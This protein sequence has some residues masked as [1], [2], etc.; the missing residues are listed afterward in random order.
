M[1][2][3]SRLARVPPG[4]GEGE[5]N[6]AQVTAVPATNVPTTGIPATAI[7]VTS[8]SVSAA[9]GGFAR[10]NPRRPY[11]PLAQVRRRAHEAL[12]ELLGPQLYDLAGS[13]DD[14]VRPIL[15]AL[16]EVLAKEEALTASDRAKAYQQ[17][18]D[19]ILGHGPI[20]PLLRDPDVT[21]IMVNS[22]DR[23]YV[24]RFGQIHNVDAAFTD[25]SHL[26]RVI[27]R[28]V[29][30]VGRRVDEASPMV[31]ARLPDGSRVNAVIPP[32]AIDG[33]ALTVRKFSAE[34]YTAED[35]I[36]FGTL[37]PQVASF[38]AACILGRLDIVISGGTGSGKTTLLNVLSGYLPSNE[39]IITIEDSAELRLSQEHVLR[40]EYRPPNIEGAG[41]VT[42]RDLVRNALRMRPD[43]IVVGEVRD[44]AALDMLQAMNT[45]HDGS[46]TTV[47]ANSP[48]DSISRLETMVMMAGME[49]PIRAI[50][51]QISSAV[52]LI[53][54]LARLRDGSRRI[55]QITEVIGM[56]GGTLSTQ[57]LYGFDYGA[58]R[59][60]YG[61]FSG[62][63]RSTGVRPRFLDKLTEQGIPIQLDRFGIGA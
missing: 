29:S 43:R 17:I 27:D 46:L 59:D 12:L 31:D 3:A 37:T 48:R 34:P 15:E 35:L 8:F 60:G 10:R 51:E 18:V 30:R 49:L 1:S 58:G 24:E 2:L 16:P 39:R 25:E 4:D 40:M 53:V 54:Q 23:I 11:D 14:L 56:E 47:H 32:I 19:E 50:R 33:A 28:I 26:R 6:P 57:E 38:L 36:S 63:V 42:I 20:E 22:W 45:G 13:D 61:R 5:G 21:E 52:D 7:P 41:E 44:A 9:A 62:Q 55:V